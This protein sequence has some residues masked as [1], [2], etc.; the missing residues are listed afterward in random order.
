M[1]FT[2]Q[3]PEGINLIRR[4]GAGFIAIGENEIRESCLV[5]A[6]SFAFWTPRSVDELSVEH[7]APVFALKPEVVVLSTGVQQIF[8]R[9]ALRAEF[10]TRKI[11]IE[12]MELGAAC[13]TYNVL[14]GE[15]R[16]VLAAILLPGPRKGPE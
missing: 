5:S 4:Y 6:N 2:L 14:V 15:E 9:A 13:R 8:P 10:A 16:H 7:L 3:R 12:V 1:K 11:G